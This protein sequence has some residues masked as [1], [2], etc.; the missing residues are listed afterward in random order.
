MLL[1][2]TSGG[3]SQFPPKLV[4]YTTSPRASHAAFV[5]HL[6][7]VSQLKRTS[8]GKLHTALKL[9]MCST[10]YECTHV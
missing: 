6:L 7:Q 2:R 1:K 10:L 4:Q 9:H 5:P 3:H 8:G